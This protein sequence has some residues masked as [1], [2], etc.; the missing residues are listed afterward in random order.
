MGR[1][2]LGLEEMPIIFCGT[3]E[4]YSGIKLNISVN[5]NIGWGMSGFCDSF[6][7]L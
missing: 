6:R 5:E 2:R 1:I 4:Y 3:I 7:G